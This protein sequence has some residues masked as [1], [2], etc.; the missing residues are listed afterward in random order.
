MKHKPGN[1]YLALAA[2]QTT[3][4]P[5]PG[6]EWTT[7]E[8]REMRLAQARDYE[9]AWAAQRDALL[10]RYAGV[11]PWR[12]A[13]SNRQLREIDEA[14]EAVREWLVEAKATDGLA[15]RGAGG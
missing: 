3:P 10:E 7:E 12:L 15:D 5:P 9:Q 14:L 8:Q 13:Q 11:D 4:V 2:A 1:R 6:K